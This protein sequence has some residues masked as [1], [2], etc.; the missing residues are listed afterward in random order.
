[1]AFNNLKT[2]KLQD[3]TGS[4]I[5]QV[6]NVYSDPSSRSDFDQL[7]LIKGAVVDSKTFTGGLPFPDSLKLYATST[8]TSG[9]ATIAPSDIY[10]NDLDSDKYLVE[11]V[12]FSSVSNDASQVTLVTIKDADANEVMIDLLR[13]SSPQTGGYNPI[14]FNENNYLVITEAQGHSIVFTGLFSIVSRGGV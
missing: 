12:R 13:P 10:P 5:A 6:G 8:I 2:L 4:Q 11:L 7:K 1:M 3:I 9:S 14:Y